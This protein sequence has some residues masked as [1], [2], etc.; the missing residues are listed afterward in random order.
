MALDGV[1]LLRFQLL[2]SGPAV[3]AQIGTAMLRCEDAGSSSCQAKERLDID[4]PCTNTTG[5]PCPASSQWS[6]ALGPVRKYGIAGRVVGYGDLAA[7]RTSAS[8]VVNPLSS[9]G[10][11]MADRRRPKDAP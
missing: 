8:A 11:T 3:T 5:R 9:A 6:I 2:A 4:Q 10:L 1:A 7:Q